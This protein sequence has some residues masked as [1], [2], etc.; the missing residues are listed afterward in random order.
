MMITMIL[1]TNEKQQLTK[2]AID[3]AVCEMNIYYASGMGFSAYRDADDRGGVSFFDSEKNK[4][5]KNLAKIKTTYL[6]QATE[7]GLNHETA[8]TA[9]SKAY[10]NAVS[11]N[12]FDDEGSLDEIVFAQILIA[13]MSPV[14]KNS[15]LDNITRC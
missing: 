2:I 15:I 7:Y 11:Q 10:A 13:A 12:E 6:N 3:R 9:Y 4:A 5:I 1:K 14:Q 8:E